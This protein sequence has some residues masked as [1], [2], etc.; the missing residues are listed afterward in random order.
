MEN[1]I[2]QIAALLEMASR[3][4]TPENERALAQ[5]KANALMQLHR[6]D[7]S[8]LSKDKGK[9]RELVWK[10]VEISQYRQYGDVRLEMQSDIMKNFGIQCIASYGSATIR[11]VGYQEDFDLADMMWAT[12]HLHF[13]SK[14]YPSWDSSRDLAWNVYTQK[15][16]AQS[17]MEIIRMA[18]EDQGLHRNSGNMLRQLY[19]KECERRG[20]RPM[21]HARN[22]KKFREAFATAY[23]SAIST[24]LWRMQKDAAEARSESSNASGGLA[25]IEDELKVKHA[26]WEKYPHMKPASDE[27]RAQWA[28]DRERQRELEQERRAALTPKEREAEDRKAEREAQARAKRWEKE[29]SI[30]EDMGYKAGYDAG[31]EADLGTRKDVGAGSKAALG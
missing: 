30:N 31:Q 13:V 10:N 1:K 29:S 2:R 26:F 4:D 15:N 16:A 23:Q 8:Q 3:E 12:V 25:L 6:I 7:I 24:R 5:Q 9:S 27:M 22:P 17:W 14:L 21:E 20:E 28:R 11:A 18:P 19:A